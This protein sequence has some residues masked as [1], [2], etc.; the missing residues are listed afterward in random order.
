M[1]IRS[2]DAWRAV[3]V[4]FSLLKR[5]TDRCIIGGAVLFACP[6]GEPEVDAPRVVLGNL[7][8]P[9]QFQEAARSLD[10]RAFCA[11]ALVRGVGFAIEFII[12]AETGVEGSSFVKVSRPAHSQ[13]R[14]VRIDGIEI[15]VGIA[16][17]TVDGGGITAQVRPE[18]FAVVIVRIATMTDNLADTGLRCHVR[19]ICVVR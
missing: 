6:A 11:P 15:V 3:T 2:Q 16:V 14:T 5:S 19:G 8:A 9:A 7:T 18:E 4:H 10:G 1:L 13:T 17:D 12:P